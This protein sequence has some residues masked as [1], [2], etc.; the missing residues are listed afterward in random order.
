M[1]SLAQIKDFLEPKKLAVAGVSRNKKKFGHAVFKELREKDFEVFPI[2][3]N[4]SEIEGVKCYPGIRELPEEVECLHIVTPK[5]QTLD[6]LKEAHEKG[7]KK[8]WI[9]QSSDTPEAIKFA[10]EH[11]ISLIH[12]KCILMYAEP[13]TN[14]HKIH[15]I[16]NKFFGLYPK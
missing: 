15:R 6:I 13:V 11:D 14:I 5:A 2:N 4:T 10:E 8:V 9:Q 16:L 3:P 12:K 1:I 7:I